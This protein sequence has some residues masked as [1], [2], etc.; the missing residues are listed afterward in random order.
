MD[1]PHTQPTFR[2]WDSLAWFKLMEDESK[3]KVARPGHESI[4]L[5]G[6]VVLLSSPIRLACA[7]A[8]AV[9][10]LSVA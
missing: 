6:A 4:D 7:R 5:A 3:S 8:S 10:N 9:T 1:C 2:T